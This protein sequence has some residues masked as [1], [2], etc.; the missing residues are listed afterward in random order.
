MK[1]LF[2]AP[3]IYAPAFKEHSKNKT[4]FGFMVYDIAKSVGKLDNDVRVTL[5]A[6]GPERRCENFTILKNSI[7]KNIIPM[8]TGKTYTQHGAFFFKKRATF[9]FSLPV[10]GKTPCLSPK[11]YAIIEPNT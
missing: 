5:H 7:V 8:S 11:A 2:I 1:V 4:G 6:F 3:Y 9:P 10:F